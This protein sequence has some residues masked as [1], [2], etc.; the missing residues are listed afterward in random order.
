MAYTH[1][2]YIYENPTSLTAPVEGDS[3]IQV[4]VG[5]APVNM[6]MDTA[7]AVNNPVIVYS[8][9]EALQKLGYSDNFDRFTLCQS[10]DASFRVFNVAPVIFINV[11]DPEKHSHS[12]DIRLIN[13]T[14]GKTL[15]T[16]EGILLPTVK[17]KKQ[18]TD[19][20]F[21]KVDEDYTLAFDNNGYVILSVMSRDITS[22]Y[23]GYDYLDTDSVTELDIIGGY[24]TASGVYKGL[25]LVDRIYPS[26]GV[27]PGQILAPG[28]SR[29][30]AVNA[31]MTAKTTNINGSFKCTAVSDIDTSAAKT[32]DAVNM[33]KNQNGYADENMIA[34]WPMAAVGGKRYHMSALWAAL[35]AYLDATN[36]SVPYKS[37]S[38]KGFRITGTVLED[39]SEVYLDQVQGNYLNSIGVCTA[40]NMN[41]W[42]SWGNNTS[43]Y[44]SVTDVKDRFIAVRRMFNWWGNSFI[45]SYFQKVDDPMD[46]RLIESV[47]DS[48]NIRANGY[49][50]RGMIASGKIEFRAD[51]NPLTDILNGRIHF[52]QK[53]ALFTPAETIVN[54]LEFDPYALQGALTG[55]DM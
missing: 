12:E 34:C 13:L 44:P 18:Q 40:I 25:E 33:W 53:L 51:Q 47:V 52:L 11:L 38:N 46:Y 22:L 7:K 49:Q 14:G 23:V 8:F 54:T 26:L 5:T 29:L 3:A 36:E 9:A 32:Y 55:G 28:W 4:V 20:G 45:L 31:V 30:P 37:P 17:V 50:A 21:L 27:L 42:K 48:E 41:G 39:G 10:M 1:G 43:I 6:A 16:R 24:N 15:I 19:E 2:V 35:T